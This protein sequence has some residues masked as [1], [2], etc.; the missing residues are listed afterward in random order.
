MTFGPYEILEI[1][2]Q[3]WRIES[4]IVRAFLF[5]GTDRALLV[6]TTN[7][8]GPLDE[9]VRSLTALPVLLVNT[10]ADGDHIS[11]NDRFAEA[12]MHPAEFSDYAQTRKPGFAAPKPL[13]DGEILDL[14]GR[15]F[16]VLLLP[17]HTPGSIALLE[18]GSGVLVGGD[19]VSERP[20]F[21]FGE[22]R[23]L[24][25]YLVSLRRL[26]ARSDEV[27]CVYPAHGPFPLE[28]AQIARQL[29]CAEKLRRG[30]LSPQEPPY[31]LPAKMYCAEGASIYYIPEDL[32]QFTRS[33]PGIGAGNE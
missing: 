8:P 4:D 24:E 10:H 21:L 11:A 14:G 32:E 12:W 2:A 13:Q 28:T 1:D 6:D 27:S 20:V 15:R 25:A 16:E 30:E 18:R 23:S 29:L 26:L 7:R 3:S 17:G 19:C 5:A 33:A 22:M 9:A 31:P